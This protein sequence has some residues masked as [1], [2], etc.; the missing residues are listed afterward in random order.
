MP[1]ACEKLPATEPGNFLSY[2]PEQTLAAG[3]PLVTQWTQW[4]SPMLAKGSSDAAHYFQMSGVRVRGTI[5]AG[6]YAVFPWMLYDLFASCILT[7]RYSQRHNLPG[8]WWLNLFRAKMRPDLPIVSNFGVVF[9][10]ETRTFDAVLPLPVGMLPATIPNAGQIPIVFSDIVEDWCDGASWALTTMPAITV[11]STTGIPVG[12]M[13]RTDPTNA[14]TIAYG[15]TSGLV[16]NAMYQMVC[17][18]VEGQLDDKKQPA[19]G[20]L[21]ICSGLQ[22]I[23]GQIQTFQLGTT[24]Q[25]NDCLLIHMH[26]SLGRYAHADADVGIHGAY[27]DP[28]AAITSNALGLTQCPAPLLVNEYQRYQLPFSNLATGNGNNP[29]VPDPT[30]N[31]CYSEQILNWTAWIAQGSSTEHYAGIDWQ[32]SQP[33]GSGYFVQGYNPALFLINAQPR[34]TAAPNGATCDG[35][36]PSGAVYIT[37]AGAALAGSQLRLHPG[38]AQLANTLPF[39][40]TGS[41]N[42][43]RGV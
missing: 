7:D 4:I 41:P 13:A 12:M 5:K 32:T 1:T 11:G 14:A 25:S 27:W 39:I 29:F 33:Y 35:E 17:D 3:S 28:N 23:V 2:G 8:G 34:P 6:T 18:M 43:N 40:R 15:A 10:G 9:P 20:L 42:A 24:A 21:R 16:Y 30:E 26:T 36:P 38:L 31:R 37:A 22:P 19:I